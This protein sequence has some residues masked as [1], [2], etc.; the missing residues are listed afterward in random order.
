MSTHE[1][2]VQDVTAGASRRQVSSAIGMPQSTY[3]RQANAGRFDAE[4]IIAIARAYGAHPVESLTKLEFLT[5]DEAAPMSLADAARLLTDQQLI[6]ELARRVD[7]DDDAWSGTFD[8]VVDHADDNVIAIGG[9]SDL[10]D[11]VAARRI[12]GKSH[13]EQIDDQFDQL[14]E[15]SQDPGDDDVDP[16]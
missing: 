1:Q 11:N 15:E 3:N 10:P 9:P 4:T 16:A 7:A 2:W 12:P 5:V 13:G 8:D 14:G 6:R